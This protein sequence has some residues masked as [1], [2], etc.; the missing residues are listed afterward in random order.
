M[1]RFLAEDNGSGA[2]DSR[3]VEARPSVSANTGNSPESVS[4]DHSKVSLDICM[5]H[6]FLLLLRSLVI[7]YTL[8]FFFMNSKPVLTLICMSG[9][10]FLVM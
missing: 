4:T 1:I 2:A 9:V 5:E 6:V 8:V 7:L 10:L 3:F